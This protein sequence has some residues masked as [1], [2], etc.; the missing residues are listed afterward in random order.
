MCVG[1]RFLSAPEWLCSCTATSTVLEPGLWCRQAWDQTVGKMGEING[2][3]T[4]LSGGVDQDA[5]QC[6]APLWRKVSWEE[7]REELLWGF[8]VS[9]FRRLSSDVACLW[10]PSDWLESRWWFICVGYINHYKMKWDRWIHL[11]VLLSV[12][13]PLLYFLSSSCQFS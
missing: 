2:L 12:C 9:G 8:W 7:G 3:G 13:L 4:S 6:E 1:V 10:S 5:R 11:P